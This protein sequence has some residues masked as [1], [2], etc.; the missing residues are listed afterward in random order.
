MAAGLAA[1]GRDGADPRDALRALHDL[2]LAPIRRRHEL[3]DHLLI[4]P[5][6]A[7]HLVPFAALLD[8]DGR[9]LLDRM[10][11]TYLTS[12][13]DLV[14]LTATGRARS[15]PLVIALSHHGAA[16]PE[17]P[18]AEAEALAVRAHFADVDLRGGPA[19]T[20]ASLAAAQ[21]PL[22]VHVATH[23]FVE[24]SRPRAPRAIGETS[25]LT[26]DIVVLTA[27]LPLA[28]RVDI[29]DA[30]DSAG[31]LFAGSGA[32]ETIMTARDLAG[33]DLQGTQ[34]VVLSACNTGAGALA[35]SEGVYGLRRALAIAGAQTQ[36]VS[37][38]KVDDEATRQLMDRFYRGLRD[39]AGRSEALLQAQRELLHGSPYAHPFYW[40]AFVPVGDE[41][42]LA[43]DE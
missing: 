15:K 41:R 35:R 43:H 27:A 23:G 7:L 22:F 17:I 42:P 39:G 13:R 34:L 14:A 31:L 12:G 26:R 6:G 40:S 21:G 2:V 20:R 37:L 32:D 38:W 30:L 29:E 36:V 5:D 11:I 19:A 18:G 9:Y 8:D 33:I 10:R 4:S 25:D 3:T 16:A 28:E 24:A 1:L